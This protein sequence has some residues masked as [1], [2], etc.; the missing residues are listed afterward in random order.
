MGLLHVSEPC[1]ESE[2]VSLAAMAMRGDASLEVRGTAQSF[3]PFYVGV[4]PVIGNS[5]P[6]AGDALYGLIAC[7]DGLYAYDIGSLVYG[8]HDGSVRGG[9]A[10]TWVRGAVRACHEGAAGESDCEDWA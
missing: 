1:T 9:L 8:D 4:I 2:A 3:G 6:L 10:E 7:S 5:G